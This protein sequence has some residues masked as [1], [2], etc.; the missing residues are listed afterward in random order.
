MRLSLLCRFVAPLVALGLASGCA[1]KQAVKKAAV[2]ELGN[3]LAAG[4]S[5]FSADDDPE[6]IKAAAP[7]SLKLMETVLAE[8]PK[9]EGLL[10][11]ASSGFTQYAYA[12]VQQDADEKEDVDLTAS[13]EL[14]TR[15]RKLYLRARGYGLR[16]LEVRHE[17]VEKALRGADPRAA[18]RSM[19]AADVP[20]LYWT[21]AAWGSA[22]SNSKDNPDLVA[23]VPI[24]EAL[25]D[26]ALELDEGFD[27]GAIHSF[28]IAFES[29]RVGAPGDPV[30]R[31]R[32]Q[33]DRTVALSGG[34]LAG[35]YV[36][37]AENVS[38]QQQNLGEFRDLLQKALAIDVDATPDSRLVNLAMQRR[39]RWLLGRTEQLFIVKHP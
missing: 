16:G 22:I 20:L 19:T 34:K 32:A 39:A 24:V 11:A 37:L 38:I 26:R 18:L 1:V 28:L 35:P 15:A 29:V 12:F 25:I 30:A 6:L 33:F 8:D 5:T 21:A 31:A 14:K 3:A 9:H 13:T 17:G 23:D 10:L 2:T 4:G 7:F 27:H 36:S